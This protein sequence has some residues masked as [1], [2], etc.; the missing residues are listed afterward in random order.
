MEN[1]HLLDDYFGVYYELIKPTVS[2]DEYL[3]WLK[4]NRFKIVSL[5]KLFSI[6]AYEKA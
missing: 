6:E 5:D 4:A 1:L 3:D 2:I